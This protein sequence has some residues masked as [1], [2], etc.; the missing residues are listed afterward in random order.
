VLLLPKVH[1]RQSTPDSDFGQV[2]FLK[3]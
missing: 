3:A 2:I 1:V